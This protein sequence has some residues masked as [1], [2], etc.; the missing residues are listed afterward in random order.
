MDIFFNR[1][2]TYLI[3]DSIENV[4]ENL[5]SITNRK[6]L[7]FSDN[8]SGSISL[9]GNYVFTQKWSLITTNGVGMPASLGVKPI[10]ENDRTKMQTILKP[11]AILVLLFYL[12]A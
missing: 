1:R 8:I 6:W 7:D 11:N 10:E 4:R 3:N 9:N 5:Q 12:I 2:Y